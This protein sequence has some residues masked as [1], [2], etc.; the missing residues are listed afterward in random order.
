MLADIKKVFAISDSTFFVNEDC[1]V[2]FCGKYSY[3]SKVVIYFRGSV[4]KNKT[5]GIQRIV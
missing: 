4:V 3:K 2:F 1:E 5:S